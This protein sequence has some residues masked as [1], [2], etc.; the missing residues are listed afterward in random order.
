[1]ETLEC[2]D[3]RLAIEERSITPLVDPP[4]TFSGVSVCNCKGIV[5][6]YE[7]TG[8]AADWMI[9]VSAPARDKIFFFPENV[10]C[11]LYLTG[12][13]EKTGIPNLYVS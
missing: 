7:F 10:L 11:R 8:Y 2:R 13:T 12:P 1:V 5:S 3:L 4:L 9:R 6:Q